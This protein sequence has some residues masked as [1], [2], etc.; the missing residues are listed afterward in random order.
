[1]KLTKAE[2]R[3][4]INSE[5]EVRV[6]KQKKRREDHKKACRKSKLGKEIRNKK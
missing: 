5:R 1:M 3:N 2:L 4:I 6:A